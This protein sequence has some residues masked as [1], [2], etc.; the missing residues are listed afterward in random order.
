MTPTPAAQPY[1]AQVLKGTVDQVKGLLKQLV[2]KHQCIGDKDT[3]H[4]DVNVNPELIKAG[5]IKLLGQ[6]DGLVDRVHFE[7]DKVC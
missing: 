2:L 4:A 5:M 6:E 1:V 3:L 7:I